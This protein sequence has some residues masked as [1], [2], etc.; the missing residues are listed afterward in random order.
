MRP[1]SRYLPVLAVLSVFGANQAV[2]PAATA[3]THHGITWTFGK[4]RPTGQ[5]VTGDYWVVGP[6]AVVRISTDLHART[7]RPGPDDDGSMVNPK[8]DSLQGYDGSLKSYRAHLNAARPHGRPLGTANPLVLPPHSSL[9]SMV[10]WLYTSEKHKELGTPRFNGHTKAPRPVTRR[11]AILTVL[12]KAPPAGSFRPAYCGKDKTVRF[13]VGDL[14]YTQLLNL[15]P[16]PNTPDPG[17]LAKQMTR[18]WIDHVH[19][20]A[21]AMLHP[22][23]NMPNYGRDMA[24]IVSQMAL[25]ANLDFSKLP[26][27]P[28]KAET[29]IPLVQYGI[30]SVGIADAGGGWPENGGHGLGRKLP[31][32]LAGALLNDPHMLKVG[33]WKT[34]FQDDEQTFYV[35]RKEVGI[36][37]SEVWRPDPRA[38]DKEPYRAADIGM[39]EWGVRHTKRPTADN[40]G[41]RTPYRDINGA[42]IPGFALAA[43]MM[44]RRKDWN[45][46]AYFDYAVR[47][48]IESRTR[49]NTRG[50]NA[51]PPFLRSLWDRYS[52]QFGL[53]RS[54]EGTSR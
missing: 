30:D 40:R 26:N 36:T 14:D 21:G 12:P 6:V 11:G 8:A 37:N 5:F 42:A 23:E 29:V 49:G 27:R 28:G 25:L 9:V 47:Y 53:A 38:R 51:P 31:I 41:W 39:A 43:C 24:K 50:T 15:S 10:S 34:R 18:P 17:Q 35:T 52:K 3:V 2:S 16:V 4:D 44:G 48:M 22:S 19:E 20:Y 32:L 7:F 1:R 33:S 46:E 45:H 54:P 13:H